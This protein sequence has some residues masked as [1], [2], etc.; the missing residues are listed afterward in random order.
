MVDT[1]P[2]PAQAPLPPLVELFDEL[3]PHLT[4]W[5]RTQRWY[6]AKAAGDTRL[7]L[8]GAV[9]LAG[10]ATHRVLDT[11]IRVEAAGRV[12]DYQVPLVLSLPDPHAAPATD[13]AAEIGVLAVPGGPLRVDDA[14]RTAIGRAALLDLVVHERRAD[15]GA[16]ALTGHDVQERG[17]AAVT[18]SRLLSGE[19]SNSSMIFELDGA[20]PVIAKLF[21]V[22]QAGENPDVVLQGTLDA[23]GSTQVAPLIGSATVDWSAGN[24]PRRGHALFV[25]EFF[26]G[27]EDA[28]RVALRD[29]VAGTDFTAGARALGE[30]TAHVHADLAAALGTTEPSAAE[31]ERIVA[32]M[33]ARLTESRAEVAEVDAAAG[34]LG[35]LLDTALEVPWPAF[36]RIHG[37]YHL[38]Q[39]LAVPGRGW[40]LLDFEGEPMRPLAERSLPDSTVRDVAGMLRSLD[41]VAG[42]VRL[43]HAGAAAVAEV[44]AWAARAREAFLAGYTET[45]GIDPA[46]ASFAVLLAAFEA[47]K[48]IYEAL[49]E[50]RNR[51]DWAPIPVTALARLIG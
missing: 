42:A 22:L 23:A 40:V 26:P 4:A 9:V 2:S 24:D 30:A 36:Q 1:P 33:H 19:Q 34:P 6:T 44:D 51:P 47:D 18:A 48:A 25:Q 32:S 10:D 29:A 41:Y 43:E 45:A 37:D 3:A 15:D 49:Y 17:R 27:V 11:V 12:T 20:P 14:P 50:V 31:R 21:R 46:D 28:W 13:A 39:V 16:L 35:A 7:T 38:G 5:I 8:A